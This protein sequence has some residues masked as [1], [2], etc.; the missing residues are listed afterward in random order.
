MREIDS[1]QQRIPRASLEVPRLRAKVWYLH[2]R[3][4]E[5]RSEHELT[6][7]LER[8]VILGGDGRPFRVLRKKWA[9]PGQTT[10]DRDWT[11]VDV[12]ADVDG[13][14]DSS[15]D[16]YRL[17]LWSF[18]MGKYADLSVL[19]EHVKSELAQRGYLR[20]TPDQREIWKYTVP[21][22]TMFSWSTDHA[23]HLH[24]HRWETEVTTADAGNMSRR[25]ETTMRDLSFAASLF[26]EAALA[27]AWDVVERWKESLLRH[28]ENVARAPWMKPTA[29]TGEL[30]LAETVR[31][32]LIDDP[33]KPSI[34]P[35]DEVSATLRSPMLS[36]RDDVEW[37]LRMEDQL[38][39]AIDDLVA[40][41]Q[42]LDD[43]VAGRPSATWKR[44]GKIG[45][46]KGFPWADEG[47]LVGADSKLTHRAE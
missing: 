45:F 8:K 17:P 18:L 25:F 33:P 5:N 6:K 46:G 40:N 35:S 42:A 34:D 47:I 16:I 32:R 2:A 31:K 20:P 14:Y 43:I 15:R 11:L 37:F 19:H 13:K 30:N 22:N 38:A 27:G 9:D 21:G 12:L 23:L 26:V 44:I 24:F 28:A 3:S 29:D 7:L 41:P 36:I 4:V 10:R 39:A 1:V